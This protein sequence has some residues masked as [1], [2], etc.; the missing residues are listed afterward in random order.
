MNIV[1]IAETGTDEAVRRARQCLEDSGIVAFPTETFYGLAVRYNDEPALGRLYA[2]KQRPEEKALPLLIGDMN[3]LEMLTP[4]VGPEAERIMARFWPGPVTLLF[5]AVR[6][7]SALI[8]AGT[9]KVGVRMPGQSFALELARFLDF[10]VT[11]T[12]ANI[13][14]SP[15]ADDPTDVLRYFGAH[16]IMLI[17][18]GKTPGGSAS[19]I[20][21]L[22]GDRIMVVRQGVVPENEILG[23]FGTKSVLRSQ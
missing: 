3:M 23:L 22:T 17:D 18:G 7:L 13:S 12:S 1:R 10:P 2:I 5:P 20:V 11:A 21:D 9:G 4:S 16:D 15:P 8:T 6:G 14:G 19:T